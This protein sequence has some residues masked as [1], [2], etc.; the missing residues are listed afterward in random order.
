MTEPRYRAFISYSHGDEPWARWLHRAL[1]RYRIPQ[2]L[3]VQHGLESNRLLP[4]FRDR[5]ELSTSSSLSAVIEDALD[6][7]EHLIVICSSAAAASRWVNEEIKAFKALGKAE[8]IL[9]LIVDGAD[10]E[11]FP[12]A[13][14]NDEP[15]G[16]DV[17]AGGDGKHHAKL[18]IISGLLG[19]GFAELQDRQVRRRNRVLGLAATASLAI[20]GVMTALAISA[21]ISGREAERNRVA[22]IAALED[23]EAVA[24]FL[25]EML[26]ELDPDAMGQTIMADVAEQAP[27][28]SLPP[29][30]NGTNTARR[31]LDE[32][33]LSGATEAVRAQFA[34]R[35]AINARLERSIGDSYQAIGLYAQ[36]IEVNNAAAQR[37][38]AEYGELDE[39]TL[40]AEQ[41]LALA[42]LYEGQL[43]EAIAGLERTLTMAR[44]SL[45]TDHVQTLSAMNSLALAYMDVRRT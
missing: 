40:D 29:D 33:L 32:H 4:I 26:A 14:L 43:D 31:L 37:Y 24:G 36:A 15:L 19:I 10:G 39:R 2:K 1:E 18:K 35:P 25:S 17:R 44:R 42:R 9:C 7:S 27:D 20:A 23:A 16:A 8:R 5:D 38:R 28:I 11:Y 6:R 22:A 21:F 34:T 12:P 41:A 30:I 45:G 3:V 13:L